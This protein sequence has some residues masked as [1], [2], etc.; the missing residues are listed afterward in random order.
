MDVMICASRV[1][2]ANN[3][4]QSAQARSAKDALA[5][6]F[7]RRFPDRDSVACSARLSLKPLR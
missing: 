6:D 1:A 2:S 4:S 7:L 3:T 5:F